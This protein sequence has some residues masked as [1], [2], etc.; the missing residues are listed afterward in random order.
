MI[1]T[2][3]E[4]LYYHDKRNPM[5]IGQRLFLGEKKMQK[6]SY[7]EEK[8]IALAIIQAQGDLPTFL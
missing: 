4:F 5:Q 3:A 1:V 7:F 2:L 8:R 6:S